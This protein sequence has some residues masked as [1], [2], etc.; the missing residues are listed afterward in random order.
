V[1]SKRWLVTALLVG[2]GAVFVIDRERSL[3]SLREENQ[4]LRQKLAELEA[5]RPDSSSR[6]APPDATAAPRVAGTATPG[7]TAAEP[8][9]EAATNRIARMLCD[10]PPR[11]TL[12]QLQRH[13]DENHR[14]AS[15]LISAYR[16][17][18]DPAL[19][20]EAM[21]KYP[22]DPAVAFEAI[23]KQDASPAERREW[24]DAFKRGA[25][26]NPLANYLSAL[27]Y[28]KTRQPDQALQELAATS[29][30]QGLTD[31]TVERIR[32]DEEAYRAAGYSE[33][34]AKMAATWGVPLPQLAQ[35]RELGQQ[36]INLA[37]SYRQAGDDNSALATLQMAASLG[38][39]MDASTGASVPI[40]TR[41]IGVAVEKMALNAMDPSSAYG[42]GTVQQ[43]LDE[44]SQRRESIRGLV[45]QSS[46]LQDQMTPGDWLTYNER[47]LSFGEENAIAWLLNKYAQK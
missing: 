12:E 21:E 5:E 10:G 45:S 14:S 40:I 31:Y 23:F 30:R 18:G 4:S 13:L 43:R 20:R 15:S 29:D 34:D 9:A 35:M 8:E 28:F 38:Q 7:A 44:L 42:E 41:L 16:T 22:G 32:L 37:A 19:L 27:E 36:M 6:H 25:P 39:K 3:T 2:A 1:N 26:E 24:L 46:P 47:T 17:S 11:L 33:G